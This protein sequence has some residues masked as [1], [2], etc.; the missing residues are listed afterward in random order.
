M[1]GPNP[2]TAAE[3]ADAPQL[4]GEVCPVKGCAAMVPEEEC[5]CVAHW[6][7]TPSLMRREIIRWAGFQTGPRY[8]SALGRAV[9]SANFREGLLAKAREAGQPPKTRRELAADRQPS[10]PGLAVTNPG[11]PD[12]CSVCRTNRGRFTTVLIHGK[13][14][15]VCTNCVQAGWGPNLATGTK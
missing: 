14:K 12:E 2:T 3:L 8:R 11:D 5:M 13:H 1:K 9:D 7:S 10:L 6:E 4:D 15:L